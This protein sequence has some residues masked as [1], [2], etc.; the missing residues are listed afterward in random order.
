MMTQ[1]QAYPRLASQPTRQPTWRSARQQ[2]HQYPQQ[3]ISTN[4]QIHDSCRTGVLC[5]HGGPQRAV[6]KEGLPKAIAQRPAPA[7]IE[8][9]MQ[10]PLPDGPFL[11]VPALQVEPH[12]CEA[13]LA[14][15]PHKAVAQLAHNAAHPVQQ[16]PAE[17][18]PE[19]HQ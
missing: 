13:C 2:K 17:Q 14:E 10:P 7:G 3:G 11:L 1:I 4:V 5:G 9:G 16:Q 12:E 8:L 19:L 18:C 6:H 15:Q